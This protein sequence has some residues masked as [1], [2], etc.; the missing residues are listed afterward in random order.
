MSVNVIAMSAAEA[1]RATGIRR[2]AINQAVRDGTL[3]AS[4]IGRRTVILAS[5]LEAWI[6]KLPRPTRRRT[7]TENE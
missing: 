6:A 5:D 4:Q 7:K 2:Q 1:S 3:P